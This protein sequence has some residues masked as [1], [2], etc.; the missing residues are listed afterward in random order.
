MK[1]IST[2]LLFF[3]VF[4]AKSQTISEKLGAV[5]TNFKITSASQ[6]LN[7]TNQIILKQNRTESK[8]DHEDYEY[9][10]YERYYF[11]FISDSKL[12]ASDRSDIKKEALVKSNHDYNKDG[13][14]IRLYDENDFL[15]YEFSRETGVRF[16]RDYNTGKGGYFT[17]EFYLSGFPLVLLDKVKR[18]D[19]QIID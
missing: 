6:P 2:L 15:I 3:I 10:V 18:I 4:G 7:V 1:K 11:Q 14:F 19:V 5:S 16:N 13:Y 8:K 9:A 12:V 17:Y